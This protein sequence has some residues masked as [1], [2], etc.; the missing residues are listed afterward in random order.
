MTV[1]QPVTDIPPRKDIKIFY[2]TTSMMLTPNMYLEADQNHKETVA[3]GATFA[4]SFEPLDN[5]NENLLI[6]EDDAEPSK[7]KVDGADF[8]FVFIIDRSGSMEGENIEMAREALQLFMQSLP[9]GCKFSIISFGDRF[10]LHTDFTPG[11]ENK[12]GVYSYSDS[13]LKSTIK[14]IGKFEADFGGTQ[15]DEPLKLARSLTDEQK[16]AQQARIFVLTDG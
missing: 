13:I 9:D 11:K 16:Y 6:Y 12:S 8:H 15:L 1:S 10:E 4:P 7:I 14:A 5:P 2:K 3:V